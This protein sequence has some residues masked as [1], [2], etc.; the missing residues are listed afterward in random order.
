MA[1]TDGPKRD[2]ELQSLPLKKETNGYLWNS[3]SSSHKNI[4][5]NMYIKGKNGNSTI[6][7]VKLMSAPQVNQQS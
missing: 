5:G 1:Y 7:Y 3:L 4:Q 6:S 2:S